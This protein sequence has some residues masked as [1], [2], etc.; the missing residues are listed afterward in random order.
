MYRLPCSSSC[1]AC[2]SDEQQGLCPPE[3]RLAEEV[4]VALL[5]VPEEP[6]SLRPQEPFLVRAFLP[7]VLAL[8]VLWLLR[9]QRE[10][11]TIEV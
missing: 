4:L 2:H 6:H 11:V 3:G 10:Q 1:R 5:P 7:R 8:L 9:Q